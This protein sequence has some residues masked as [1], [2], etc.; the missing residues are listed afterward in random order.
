[1]WRKAVFLVLVSLLSSVSAQEMTR[2]EACKQVYCRKGGVAVVNLP[3]DR[4][5]S[6]DMTGMPV[7]VGRDVN[8][9]PGE[10]LDLEPK[11]EKGQIVALTYVEKKRPAAKTITISF[12]QD[13]SVAEGVANG[14][15]MRLIIT[16]PFDRPLRYEAYIK[17]PDGKEEYSYT[18]SCPVH[19][20][21]SA[22]EEWPYPIEHLALV[23]FKFLPLAGDIVCE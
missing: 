19:Q 5:A 7:V 17:T 21:V 16:N 4:H 8:I 14:L 3:G 23:G 13:K 6:L 18:S 10:T 22:V 20:G 11:V 2:E 15:G 1:M 12:E 9:F